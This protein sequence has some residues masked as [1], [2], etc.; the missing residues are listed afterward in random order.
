[1]NKIL[2][3]FSKMGGHGRIISLRGDTYSVARPKVSGGIY[4]SKI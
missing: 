2:N 1:M 4:E 3:N